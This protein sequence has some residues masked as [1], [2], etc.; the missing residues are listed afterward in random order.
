[1]IV[2][3]GATFGMFP[4]DDRTREWMESQG[5]GG[6]FRELRPDDGADYDDE[7][8]IDLAALEPLIAKP[9]NPDNVVPVREVAGTEVAQVCVGSS[10]NSS[11][12][13]LAIPADIVK[14]G[15]GVNQWVDMTVSPG[16]RQILNAIATSGVLADYL[17]AGAR[18]LEPACGPCVGMGQAPPSKRPSVRTM[19]RNFQGRSGTDDDEVYLASPEVAGATALN[20]VIMDPRDLGME[21]PRIA[22]PKPVTDDFMLIWPPPPEEAAQVNIMRGPNIKPPPIPPDLPEALQ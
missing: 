13:D 6:D 3:L 7:M 8:V 5:R 22:A 12:E 21:Y 11:F 19:N 2:E 16:S 10:V 14:R 18:L 15:G 1:M 9:H 20:G 4:S 17:A